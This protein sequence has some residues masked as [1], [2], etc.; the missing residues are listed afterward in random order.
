MSLPNQCADAT[1]GDVGQLTVT[2]TPNPHPTL[3]CLVLFTYELIYAGGRP[4]QFLFSSRAELQVE[5]L[6]RR[7]LIDRPPLT[8]VSTFLILTELNGRYAP[9]VICS[10]LLNCL[11]LNLS[12][13]LQDGRAAKESSPLSFLKPRWEYSSHCVA[14]Q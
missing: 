4:A 10:C 6:T 12:L 13:Q 11:P 1:G 8:N 7:V 9:G 2:P 5:A 3:T 14:A